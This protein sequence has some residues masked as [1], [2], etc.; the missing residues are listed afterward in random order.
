MVAQRG[1]LGR[2][3]GCF[4]VDPAVVTNLVAELSGGGFIYAG[5]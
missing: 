5:R 4:V 1:K 2:S 3:W